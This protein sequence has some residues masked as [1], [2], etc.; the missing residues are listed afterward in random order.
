[1]SGWE[2]REGGG[3]GIRTLV[4]RMMKVAGRRNNLNT[5]YVGVEE[6]QISVEGML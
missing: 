3:W 2:S 4:K 5:I 1:L 6:D